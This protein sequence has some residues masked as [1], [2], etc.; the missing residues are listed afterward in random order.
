MFYNSFSSYYS[1]SRRRRQREREEEMR[2]KRKREQIE[3]EIAS[4]GDRADINAEEFAMLWRLIIDKKHSVI[5]DAFKDLLLQAK[6]IFSAEIGEILA[7]QQRQKFAAEQWAIQ[8]AKE[9]V[10]R[11]AKRERLD[12]ISEKI[13]KRR[14]EL[15]EEIRNKKYKILDFRGTKLRDV[16]ELLESQ[17]LKTSFFGHLVVK[18]VNDMPTSKIVRKRYEKYQ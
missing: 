9:E 16:R 5:N 6:L 12:Y 3:N 10:R 14:Q 2:E 8:R 17:H 1:I 15:L 4:I 7:E 18:N 11:K 13:Q